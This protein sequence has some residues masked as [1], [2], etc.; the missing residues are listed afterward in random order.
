MS[1]IAKCSDFLCPSSKYCHRFTAPVGMLEYYQN[2]NR[3]GDADNCNMFWSN[4]IDSNKCKLGGVKRDGEMC[5][6]DYCTYPK[7]VQ[8]DYCEYCHKTDSEHKMSCPTRKIQIN[9]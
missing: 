6:L 5:N 1:D 7:C 2:F 8:D 9:L 4:G 3:E